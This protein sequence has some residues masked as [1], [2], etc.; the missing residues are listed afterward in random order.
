MALEIIS[1]TE[2]M[3]DVM[4]DLNARRGR[5][6]DIEAR[7]EMQIIRARAPLAELFGYATAIRSLSRGRASYTLEPEAFDVVPRAVRET[8][9][10]K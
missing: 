8:L 7:G 10:S 9:M 5:V 1:P 3:G 2:A 4:G 6:K